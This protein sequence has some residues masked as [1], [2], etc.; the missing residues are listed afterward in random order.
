MPDVFLAT[1]EKLD[2]LT[3]LLHGHMTQPITINMSLE[4]IDAQRPVSVMNDVLRHR[5]ANT[6][7]RRGQNLFSAMHEPEVVPDV[8]V[9]RLQHNLELVA[10]TPH[11]LLKLLMREPMGF[12]VGIRAAQ[13]ASQ[14]RMPAHALHAIRIARVHG[15]S[16]ISG[17][18]IQRL[19]VEFGHT[20]E[21]YGSVA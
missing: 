16:R 5:L 3:Q 12:V 4:H 11:D 1:L 15:D 2:E 13:V 8:Q 20:P 9:S 10:W 6:R 14:V 21:R 19:A 18:L 7:T 17:G